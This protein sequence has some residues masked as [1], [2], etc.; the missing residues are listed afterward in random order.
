MVVLDKIT[1]DNLK[2]LYNSIKLN[3]QDANE[4]LTETLET[5]EKKEEFLASLGSQI[6]E[7][8]VEL[9]TLKLRE[10]KI[11]YALRTEGRDLG[12]QIAEDKKA[13][14]L[15]KKEA[16]R[17]ARAYSR[18]RERLSSEIKAL[19]KE[20]DKLGSVLEELY[21]TQKQLS[22]TIVE[23]TKVKDE[24]KIAEKELLQIRKESREEVEKALKLVV[25]AE[26]KLQDIK[27][28]Q[29]E[30]VLKLKQGHVNLDERERLVLKK[31]RALAILTARLRKVYKEQ[32]GIDFKL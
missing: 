22:F 18:D 5:I 2:A 7:K 9:E 30:E 3:I 25:E 13:I 1:I 17:I 24:I 32:L 28:A 27:D 10:N 20:R 12:K 19:K 15:N 14:K 4:A 23:L 21:D 26:Q 29:E 8:S 6:S 31:E 11:L 16:K